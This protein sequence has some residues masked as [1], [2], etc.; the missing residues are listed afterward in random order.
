MNWMNN[1]AY[2]QV[3][4]LCRSWSE[5]EWIMIQPWKPHLG[6]LLTNLLLYWIW[7]NGWS[8]YRW[9]RP[10]CS[11]F[12]REKIVTWSCSIMTEPIHG[13]R[14]TVVLDVEY[15]VSWCMNSLSEED[16]SLQVEQVAP[17]WDKFS[18]HNLVTKPENIIHKSRRRQKS[19]N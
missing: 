13:S 1:F 7:P 16:C 6:T 4:A 10:T 17:T 5:H 14:S 2:V 19:V 9:I 15:N 8:F 3:A 18:S 11:S 12:W